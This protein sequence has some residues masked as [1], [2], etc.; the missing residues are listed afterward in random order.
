M[1]LSEQIHGGND[2]FGLIGLK[3]GLGQVGVCQD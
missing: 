3:I 2:A 1:I